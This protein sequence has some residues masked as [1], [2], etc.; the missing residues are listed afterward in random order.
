MVI[1][2]KRKKRSQMEIFVHV[3]PS[4]EN[5]N[6][7]RRLDLLLSKHEKVCNRRDVKMMTIDGQ[8][9]QITVGVNK[10]SGLLESLREERRKAVN[11]EDER[12]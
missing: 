5:W 12:R 6:R 7:K 11:Q 10:S 9:E 1:Y 2:V 3:I 4:V 8:G